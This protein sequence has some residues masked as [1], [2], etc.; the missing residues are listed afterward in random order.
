MSKTWEILEKELAF[1]KFRLLDNHKCQFHISDKKQITATIKA[2]IQFVNKKIKE[3]KKLFSELW[4]DAASVVASPA[5]DSNC[6]GEPSANL[7]INS[8]EDL[9]RLLSCF[10][11]LEN[12]E[13]YKTINEALQKDIHEFDN[14]QINL[15]PGYKISIDWIHRLIE[16]LIYVR[17]LLK[18]AFSG[19][20][21]VN[22]VKVARGI[23]GPWANLDLAMRE[24][25]F[26]WWE[27]DE[28]F[29]GRDRDIR[30]QRRYR[31]GLENYNNDGRVGEGHFWREQRNEPF[32]W[33]NRKDDDPYPHRYTLTRN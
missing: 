21:N 23:S 14:N 11:D 13:L 8:L 27:E 31:K 28:N 2:A 4:S 1:H 22:T 25:V 5:I 3:N 17:K 16:E 15:L 18:F 32:S 9:G 26:P 6:V 10:P 20:Q 7:F 33:Y 29:R 19:R 30:N 12:T 24:R